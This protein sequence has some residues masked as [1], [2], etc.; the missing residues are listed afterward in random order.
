MKLSFDVKNDFEST[1]Y[2]PGYECKV[3]VSV[4]DG[5]VE[6]NIE[7][8]YEAGIVGHDDDEDIES[9]C[10]SSCDNLYCDNFEKRA[11]QGCYRPVKDINDMDDVMLEIYNDED[12]DGD[13]DLEDLLDEDYY[14]DDIDEVEDEKEVDITTTQEYAFVKKIAKMDKDGSIV[15]LLTTLLNDKEFTDPN[16]KLN[17]IFTKVME[18]LSNLVNY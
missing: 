4:K 8:D 15:K 3:V 6:L 17:K 18:N 9:K 12:Y 2:L 13:D 10:N 14:E 7:D 5:I 16:S 1:Y 11:Y